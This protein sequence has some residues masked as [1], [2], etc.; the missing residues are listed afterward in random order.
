MLLTALLLAST[1]P[2]APTWPKQCALREAPADAGPIAYR[3]CGEGPAV[4]IIPGGPGLDADYVAPLARMVAQIHHRAIVI[5]PRGTGAS[6]SAIGDGSRLTVAGSIADVDAVRRASGADKVVLLGHSFGG[7]VAQAYAAALPEQ[8]AGLI[9][10]DSTG[11]DMNP[12]GLSLD[13]WRTRAT[14]HELEQYDAAR[15]GGD[16][17]SAMRLKFRLNFYHRQ[18]GNIFTAALKDNNIHLDVGRRLSDAYLHDYRITTREKTEF[19]ITIVAGDIDWIRGYEPA[20]KA[21][22]PMA[23]TI[24]V[25]HAGH[26]SWADSPSAFRVAL[27]AAL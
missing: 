4:L 2:P 6:R 12:S 9:L 10:L 7:A 19:P 27:R 26:F 23:R 25:P 14:A 21:T 22:Y 3:D 24:I 18:R 8:L 1:Q 5:E 15:A 11:P 16:R 17:A 20:L 13:S